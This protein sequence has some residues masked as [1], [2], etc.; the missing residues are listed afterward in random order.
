MLRLG[1]T[2]IPPISFCAFLFLI[3]VAVSASA[4]Q[5]TAGAAATRQ[6][7]APDPRTPAAPPADGVFRLGEIVHVLGREPGSPGIGA[8]VVTREQ[9]RTIEKNSLDQA[10]NIAPGVASTFDAN[11]GRNE[12]DGNSDDPP[13]PVPRAS[14]SAEP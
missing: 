7:P 14:E 4:R 8:T 2:R 3:G 1:T 9:I 11:G 12:S 13:T 10:V 6:E 5:P